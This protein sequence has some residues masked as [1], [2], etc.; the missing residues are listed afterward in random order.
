MQ[1]GATVSKGQ[2]IGLVGSTGNST[3]PH[4][5]FAVEFNGDPLN[6]TSILME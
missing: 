1:D 6:P 2:V 3:E 5:H 4:L